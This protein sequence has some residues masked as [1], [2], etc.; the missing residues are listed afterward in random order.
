MYYTFVLDCIR[1]WPHGIVGHEQWRLTPSVC[2]VPQSKTFCRFHMCMQIN[3]F[4]SQLNFSVLSAIG[5]RQNDYW[6]ATPKEKDTWTKRKM[7][8]F[9]ISRF[10]K[11]RDGRLGVRPSC[12]CAYSMRMAHRH[13]GHVYCGWANGTGLAATA[14]GQFGMQEVNKSRPW[15][16]VS[17][18]SISSDTNFKFAALVHGECVLLLRRRFRHSTMQT[19]WLV[20]WLPKYI[21]MNF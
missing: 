1:C 10:H 3:Y 14:D 19:I 11:W 5:I 20:C 9:L 7:Y 21:Q 6:L 4:V 13:I 17:I 16:S 8:N 18:W 15:C 12:F 2:S